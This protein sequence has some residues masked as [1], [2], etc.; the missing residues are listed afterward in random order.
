MRKALKKI[1]PDALT[2]M[3]ASLTSIPFSPSFA[4][5]LSERDARNGRLSTDSMG[6]HDELTDDAEPEPERLF[7][8]R[9][10]ET[11]YVVVGIY[12]FKCTDEQG[13]LSVWSGHHFG[14]FVPQ[15][16]VPYGFALLLISHP[17]RYSGPAVPP[18]LMGGSPSS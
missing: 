9:D 8:L 4:S 3:G 18:E 2:S 12:Y 15:P 1:A 5:F 7:Q 10:E 6:G 16:G 17:L 11:L 14:C 13:S